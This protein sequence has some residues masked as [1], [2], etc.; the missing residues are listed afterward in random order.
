MKTTEF[1]TSSVVSEYNAAWK[2]IRTPAKVK[3][4]SIPSTSRG[5]LQKHRVLDAAQKLY[6]PGDCVSPTRIGNEIGICRQ[7]V[8]NAI[9]CLRKNNQWPYQG[10]NLGLRYNTSDAH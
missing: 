7:T 1:T 8:S 6:Q 4:V 10:G 9:A 2:R 3:L 5:R